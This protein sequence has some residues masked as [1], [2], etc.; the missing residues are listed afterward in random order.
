[1]SSNLR[2]KNPERN[3]SPGHR[4]T[5]GP[6][7]TIRDRSYTDNVLLVT[8]VNG[9]HAAVEVEGRTFAPRT[10][11]IVIEEHDWYAADHFPRKES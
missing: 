5:I 1:M 9:G 11:M 10:A 6:N 4:Y 3:L 2:V 7:K 8:H